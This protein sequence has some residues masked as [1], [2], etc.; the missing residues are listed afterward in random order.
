MVRLGTYSACTAL[1]RHSRLLKVIAHNHIKLSQIQTAA[2]NR[3]ALWSAMVTPPRHLQLQLLL[4]AAPS[5]GPAPA[6]VALHR[7]MS[8]RN[9][10]GGSWSIFWIC[11]T[12]WPPQHCCLHKGTAGNRAG[13]GQDNSSQQ[14]Q[15]FLR[16]A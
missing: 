16:P 13:R 7:E 14:Q 12:S 8:S 3:A 1:S 5:P 10:A 11:L 6:L 2:E 15:P 4:M 9:M